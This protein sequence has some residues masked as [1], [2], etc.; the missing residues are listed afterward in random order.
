[1]LVESE[2]KRSTSASSEEVEPL[3]I[4][5]VGCIQHGLLNKY[6]FRGEY[7]RW[8]S[9]GATP[10]RFYHGIGRRCD[11]RQSRFCV[12][13]SLIPS[14]HNREGSISMASRSPCVYSC[15]HNNSSC[16]AR[17]SRVSEILDIVTHPQD[18]NESLF[19]CLDS[20]TTSRSWLSAINRHLQK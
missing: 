3:V 11:I 15:S 9:P 12:R 2:L 20:T 1:L 10:V 4:P 14:P 8:S 13:P 6:D 5:A 18:H 19:L 7:C 16:C 17:F